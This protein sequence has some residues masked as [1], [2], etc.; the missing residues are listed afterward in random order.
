MPRQGP[1]CTTPTA[2]GVYPAAI[3]GTSGESE[4]KKKRAPPEARFWTWGSTQ[5]S[6]AAML[7]CPIL[8]VFGIWYSIKAYK[9]HKVGEYNKSWKLKKVAWSFAVCSLLFGIVMWLT[10]VAVFWSY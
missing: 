6:S 3:P 5:A 4:R 7:C 8:A 9:L 1:F 10:I 2:G